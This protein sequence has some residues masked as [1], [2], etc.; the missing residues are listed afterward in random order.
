MKLWVVRWL[1][2]TV[3]EEDKFAGT[4]EAET[5]GSVEPET[6]NAAKCVVKAE[7]KSAGEA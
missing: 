3:L 2:G 5:A 6:V 7:L 1:K 4:A